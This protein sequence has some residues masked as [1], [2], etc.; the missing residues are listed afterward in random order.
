MGHGSRSLIALATYTVF[1]TWQRG[2]ELVT[3]RRRALEG[4]L[5]AFVEEL[6]ARQPPL[7]RVPGT[8]I[9]LNRGKA[10]APLAM[11]ANVEHNHILHEQVVILSVETRP[12]PY[13]PDGQ[14]IRVDDLGYRDDRIAFVH[15]RFG[16]LEVPDIPAL[17]P[18]IT[19]SSIECSVD[20]DDLTYFLSKLEL[21]RGNEPGMRRWRKSLF[22][23]TARLTADAADYFRLPSERTV[24]MGSRI[25]L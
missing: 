4:P 6:H 10:T 3:K 14:R 7:L 24:V 23:A 22:L 15:A 19:A 17:L 5:Q 9:F 25:E 8:A 2:R 18:L 1:T 12:R 11:R 13:V 21:T 20:D 16:Y